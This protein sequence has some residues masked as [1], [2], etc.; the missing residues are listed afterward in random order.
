[1]TGRGLKNRWAS[2]VTR[3]G[4]FIGIWVTFQSLWQQL[5]CPNILHSLAIFEKV[6]NY[7]IFVVKSFLGNFYRHLATFYWSHWF[8]SIKLSFTFNI[9]LLPHFFFF[10]FCFCPHILF[11]SGQSYKHF[12]IMKYDCIP[13][14]DNNQIFSY[15]ECKV[16]IYNCRVFVRLDTDIFLSLF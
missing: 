11:F 14:R 5:I 4:R 8:P 16:T 12:T 15:H 7:I 1:M 6:S 13:S 9:L 3:I 10:F 2:S